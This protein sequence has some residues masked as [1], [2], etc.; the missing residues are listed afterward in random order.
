MAP[1]GHPCDMV[2]AVAGTCFAAG[3]SFRQQSCTSVLGVSMCSSNPDDM[4]LRLH[5]VL[6][7][8]QVHSTS[9]ST[10]HAITF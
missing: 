7:G 2:K 8:A 9:I 6:D 3:A 5:V 10:I 4:M 1:L